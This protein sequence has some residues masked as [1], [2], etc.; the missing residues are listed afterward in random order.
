M[1]YRTLGKSG[2]QVSALGLGCNNLGRQVD[3]PTTQA[4]I[5]KCL[6]YGMTFF[7]TADVYGAEKGKSEE[8]LGRALK[9]HRRDVVI[10]TKGGAPM[11]EGPYGSGASRRYLMNAL[12]DSLRRLDTDYIDL[13]QVHQFDPRTP[14]EETLRTLD[15]M[16][17]SGKV[18]YV[19]CS[20]HSGVQIADAA[21]VAARE[22][23]TPYISAQ[24]RYNMLE[25]QIERDVV[26][27]SL[28]H[29]LG[30]LPYYPLCAGLLTGK[31]SADFTPEGTRLTS[32]IRFYDGILENADF[33]LIDR[34]T[35]FAEDRDHTLLEL[36][37]GWLAS[38]PA[39]G[40]VITGATRVEQ[41]EQNLQSC[42]WRLT[43]EEMKQVDEL[44]AVPA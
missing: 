22:H 34:L 30:V 8:F 35:K 33:P 23:F 18:R 6:E 27:A 9:A 4:I 44:Y 38:Q 40:S 10:A 3:M 28:E 17:R 1:E 43:P 37:I 41:I 19:G 42:D 5:D 7:D 11:G 21:A 32:G 16:V 2:L 13:Y 25:R 29:G 14:L 31:Y 12:E 15:D 36:A 20:N 24:N 26:P 39:V